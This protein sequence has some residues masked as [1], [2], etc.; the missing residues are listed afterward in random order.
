MLLAFQI[1]H[2]CCQDYY[3]VVFLPSQRR[4]Q[5]VTLRIHTRTHKYCEDDQLLSSAGMIWFLIR[6]HSKHLL[7]RGHQCVHQM[8]SQQIACDRS[9]TVM[10][11]VR[12][13]LTDMYAIVLSVWLLT[14]P[15]PTTTLRTRSHSHGTHGH[16]WAIT[17]FLTATSGP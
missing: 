6:A 1:R 17:L 5:E 11:P 3:P 14:Q 7:I 15:P 4:M 2:L 13:Q 8:L 12:P 10:A 16:F 9:P